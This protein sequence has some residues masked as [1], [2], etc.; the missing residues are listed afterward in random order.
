MFDNLKSDDS[1]QQEKDTLGG[2]GVLDS[3]LYDL[4]VDHAYVSKSS[5]GA[6]ALNLKMSNKQGQRLSA[7]LWMTSGDSKGNKN[8]YEGK[9]GTKSYLPGFALANALCLLT[10]GKEISQL[11]PE[12]KV[13]PIYDFDAKKELPTKVN[14]VVDLF[15]KTITVGVLKEL[16]DKNKDTGTVDSNGKKIYA[17]T[18]ETREQNEIDKFFRAKDGLT[19]AEIRGGQATADFKTAW[20][21]KNTGVVRNKAKG[22]TTG[23]SATGVAKPQAAPAKSLFED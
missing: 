12:E 13:I 16:V 3:G 14:A 19:V 21:E 15:G 10:V 8:Y 7:Q 17:A 23:G 9:D 6:M 5:G 2:G 11:S 22:A 18:G 20:S 4:D 1:I